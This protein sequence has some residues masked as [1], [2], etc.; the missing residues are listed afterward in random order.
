MG[1]ILRTKSKLHQEHIKEERAT[2][3]DQEDKAD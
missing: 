3:K 2:I 1:T